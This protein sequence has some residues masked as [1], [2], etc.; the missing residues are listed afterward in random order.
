MDLDDDDD[1]DQKKT[2][3]RVKAVKRIIN[4]VPVRYS[5]GPNPNPNPWL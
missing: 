5:Q 4:G 3:L 1:D 2:G